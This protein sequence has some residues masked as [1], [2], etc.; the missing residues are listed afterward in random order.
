MSIFAVHYH[1]PLVSE[2]LNWTHLSLNSDKSVVANRVTQESL[3]MNS[4][5]VDLI[6]INTVCKGIHV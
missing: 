5:S 3:N 2:Y 1:N 4:S 6:W